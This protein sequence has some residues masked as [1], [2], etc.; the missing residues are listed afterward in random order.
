MLWR[1]FFLLNSCIV[2]KFVENSSI[3]IM[4]TDVLKNFM[5]QR[6]A[7]YS[8]QEKKTYKVAQLTKLM[9]RIDKSIAS[10]A[11]KKETFALLRL[12]IE[13]LPPAGTARATSRFMQQYSIL[14]KHAIMVYKFDPESQATLYL[15]VGLALGAVIG[16]LVKSLFIGLPVGAI[17]SLVFYNLSLN[18]FKNN[19]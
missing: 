4:K 12:T 16:W 10:N 14:R 1:P 11:T 3:C 13:L 7:D 2:Y 15:L 17:V 18:T 8:E 19:D 9:N 5:N 6:I